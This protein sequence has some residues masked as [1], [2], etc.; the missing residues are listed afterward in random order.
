M[1]DRDKVEGLFRHLRQYT[2]QL[3][4]IAELDLQEFLDD[5]RAIGSARYYL[6]VSIESCLNVANHVIA[7][8]RLR[9][10]RDYKDT[11]T[12]LT[13]AN[14][15]PDDLGRTMRELAGLRNLLV[16]VY[17]EVDDCMVYEGIRSEL[18]DLDL[19]GLHPGLPGPPGRAGIAIPLLPCPPASSALTADRSLPDR[20]PPPG[21]L[22]QDKAT[23]RPDRSRQTN[24]WRTC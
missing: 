21:L 14:I 13:E 22:A 4:E 9:V 7:A 2:G 3:R 12:V 1:V 6:Q 24:G 11:F 16:H 15:I 10:P 19:C 18:G 23:N 20:L 8:E 17:W 5:P